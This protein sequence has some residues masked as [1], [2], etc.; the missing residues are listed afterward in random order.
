MYDF[1]FTVAALFFLAVLSLIFMIVALLSMIH[2]AGNEE[3]RGNKILMLIF[4]VLSVLSGAY[5]SFAFF[6]MTIAIVYTVIL[7]IIG[8]F[9]WTG[10]F[11]ISHKRKKQ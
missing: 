1:L 7:F 2:F 8:A 6:G 10:Y 5:P 3:S 11:L 9:I 4:P